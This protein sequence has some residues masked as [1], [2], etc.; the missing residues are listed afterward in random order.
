MD[1]QRAQSILQVVLAE[2]GFEPTSEPNFRLRGPEFV[3]GIVVEGTLNDT[4][5]YLKLIFGPTGQREVAITKALSRNQQNPVRTP[6]I[7]DEGEIGEH[8]WM[9]T[10]KVFG[11]YIIGDAYPKTNREQKS[12]M[13][14]AFWLMTQSWPQNIEE[15]RL[16]SDH[17]P[18]LWFSGKINEWTGIGV[19]YDIF[20]RGFISMQEIL[21]AYRKIQK[22]IRNVPFQMRYTHSHFCDKELRKDA[23]GVYWLTDFG[24]TSWRPEMYDAAFCVWHILM[25]S[26]DLSERQFVNEMREWEKKFTEDTFKERNVDILR[27][28]ACM[29]ERSI[30]A[31]CA[32]IGEK[33]GVVATLSQSDHD[34]LLKS[35]RHLLKSLS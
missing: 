19:T 26:Y 27:F 11:D 5:S 10:Q 4:P 35:W 20:D 34:N 18:L 21:N 31:I 17:D 13:G 32:D 6:L 14:R 15:Q 28:Q 16:P 7:L 24:A 29:I 1:K 2:S 22:I 8:A 25:H 9:I 12:E 23:Q 3:R 33:R 30:G